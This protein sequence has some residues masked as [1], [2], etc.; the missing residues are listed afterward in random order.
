[1]NVRRF[2]SR[3]GFV[4]A[5]ACLVMGMSVFSLPRALAVPPAVMDTRDTA[6]PAA[7]VPDFEEIRLTEVDN[8][9]L[10]ELGKDQVLVINLESNPSTGYSWEVAEINQN[11]LYQMGE[12]E[13]EPMS[14]LLGAPA[15]QI[16]RFKPISPGQSTL[17]LVYRRSWEKGVEPAKSFSLQVIGSPDVIPQKGLAGPAVEEFTHMELPQPRHLVKPETS[18]QGKLQQ[19]LAGWTD[20]MTEDFEGSFPGSWSVFD[21]I[22]GSGEYLWGKRDCRPHSGS[23]SGWAVGG[24]PDGA[25]LSCGANYPLNTKPWMIYGP[26]DLSSASDAELIFWYWH[27]TETVYDKLFWGASIN[28]TN[29]YGV[30]SSGD[31]GGWNE[32][33]FDLT[34]VY[35]LGDLTGRP[36][37]WIA[38][39]FTSDLNLTY[40]EGVYLDDIV[41]RKAAGTPITPDP[42]G[43]LPSAFDWRDYGGVTSVKNQGSC[44]S[45]WSFGTVGPLEANIKIK[46]GVE[47]NLSEQYLLSCNTNG[48]DCNGGWWAHDYHEWRRPPSE[49]E[50][51]AVLE[52]DS[53]YV[54][55]RTSCNGPYSHPYQIDSWAFVGGEYSVPPA[56]A[57]KQAIYD[58]GPVAAA[59]C[60]N[61][62]FQTYSGGVFLGP[63]CTSLNHAIVLVG[64]DDNQG[65]DGVWILRNSWTSGWGESGYMRIGYGISMVGYSAN[66]V[67]YTS[68][69][70]TPTPTNTPTVV[71][72][73]PTATPTATSTSTSTPTDTPTATST[74]TPTATPTATS[75][76]TSTPADTPTATSTPTSTP[77]AT[78]TATSTPTPTATPTATPTVGP[79]PLVWV[80][81][82]E[83]TV[84]LSEGDFT[85]DVNI[86]DVAELGSF[87]FLLAFSPDIVHA[88]GATL[89][90]FLGST[91]RNT[92]PM[93]PASID[94]QAGTIAFGAASFGEPAGAA[95]SGVLATISFSPQANGASDLTLQDVKVTDT[96]TTSIPVDLQDGQVTVIANIDGDLNGDCVVDVIDIMMVASRWNTSQGQPGYDPFCDIDHDGDIDVVDIMIVASHWGDTC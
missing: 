16:L 13:F 21:N 34:N 15:K 24:G 30:S 40:P 48:W 79:K 65:T 86:A 1:M 2:L 68:Q 41:L 60:V 22:S 73:T 75:T 66:Y 32:R 67:N 31:S 81:P 6:P 78:P 90:D 62:A 70:P 44:G 26:F 25:S 88:E 63:E 76:S 72:Q 29:F 10:A 3:G 59:V 17:R 84:N 20:I 87:Q 51:G 42:P 27:F 12:V 83:K 56:A 94:N 74:P 43:D 38:F 9:G 35:Y 14:A 28:G 61:S 64:W 53:P 23:Y 47:Q 93:N 92:V 85:V 95:G 7:A 5:S 8:G 4:A 69:G 80:D 11:L 46:D 91:G 89:G 45:C 55:A 52:A 71:T 18:E 96:M 57:I 77:T 36:Q 50:A 58:H 82:P 33:N 39:V 19:S 37:V 49:S 54:A